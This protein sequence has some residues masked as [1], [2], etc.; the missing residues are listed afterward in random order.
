MKKLLRL[1]CVILCLALIISLPV[2]ADYKPIEET[3]ETESFSNFIDAIHALYYYDV[4]DEDLLTR[5]IKTL[6]KEN[7]E[8]LEEVIRS[9]LNSL[10]E[11]STY[12]NAEEWKEFLDSLEL[13]FGGIGVTISEQ[14]KYTVIMSVVE[15]MPAFNAGIKPGDKIVSVNGEDVVGKSSD[16]IR[17]LVT[18]EIGTSVDIGVVRGTEMLTFNVLRAEMKQDSVYYNK[19]DDIAYI[20]LTTFNQTTDEELAEILEQIDSEGIKKI[21]LD[22]RYNGGGYLDTAVNVAQNFVPE[23]LIAT[24]KYKYGNVEMPIYSHLEEKKYE[25]AVLINEYSASASELVSSAIQES[26]GGV[27][28]GK[29]SFG[30]AVIQEMFP[31]LEG[32]YAKMTVGAYFT[33]NGNQINKIGIEPDYKVSNREVSFEFS[34]AMPFEFNVKYKIGDKGKG[35]LAAK[36]RLAVLG[37]GLDTSNDEYDQTM[38][39]AISVFQ[40]ECGLFPYGVLDINTQIMLENKVNEVM[41]TLD[42]QLDKAIRLLGGKP[43]YDLD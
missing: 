18:G 35:V 27:L 15:D 5:A 38:A 11:Y 12:Y 42:L 40:E 28:I 29:R 3:E 7:P 8:L 36:Q 17:G 26:G 6:L 10:D 13:K 1:I 33:R 34:G 22:L 41:V 32:T 31:V 4:E 25:L 2:Y 43:L 39:D 21:V 20:Q 30:K 19:I 16:V 14:G 37:Y 23:G 9:T 24:A